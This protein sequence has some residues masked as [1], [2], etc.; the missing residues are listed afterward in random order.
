MRAPTA[1]VRAVVALGALIAV[2]VAPA[3]WG[4]QSPYRATRVSGS[5]Y[6]TGCA[7]TGPPSQVGFPYT[8]PARCLGEVTD[9]WTGYYV[10]DEQSTVDGTL[11]VRS[12][13][14][15]TLYGTAADGTCGS[16]RILTRTKVDGS[17]DALSGGATI[18]GGTGDWKGS[19]GSYRSTGQFDTVEGLGEY[20]GTWLRPRSAPKGRS[21][22]CPPPF[23]SG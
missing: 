7:L 12:R 1:P 3:A 5:W 13:G 23:P 4:K 6:V 22:P 14:V 21:T 8:A 16:L 11:S 10:D 2:A 15:I 17:N 9:S 18:V 20:H 19:R